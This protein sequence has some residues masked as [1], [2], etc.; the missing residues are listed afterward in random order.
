MTGQPVWHRCLSALVLVL[1]LVLV[2]TRRG[3][4]LW[5]WLGV[6]ASVAQ[7][8]TAPSE[9][10]AVLEL[11]RARGSLRC[12]GVP[13][14][15]LAQPLG[16]AQSAGAWQGLEPELCQAL[17]TATLGPAGRAQFLPL[18]TGVDVARVREGGADVVFASLAERQTLGL[19]GPWRATQPIY[20][21]GVSVMVPARSS[22]HRLEDLRGRGICFFI[23]STAEDALQDAM[24]ARA[25]L[26]VPH[27]FSELGEMQDAFAAHLCEALA[28][29]R[30][31][32]AAMR[33]M[34]AWQGL[35]ARL[36]EQDLGRFAIE[37]ATA[38]Q[39][40]AWAAWVGQALATL[41]A[42]RVGDDV[43]SSSRAALAQMIQRQGSYA[44]IYARTLGTDS[45]LALP[46]G[47]NRGR[48]QGGAL[49]DVWPAR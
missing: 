44:S 3:V 47:D 34:P 28:A 39:D 35:R 42:A 14:P 6:G 10:S 7:A 24:R 12:A 30:T 16:Q 17:A 33:A 40:P 29:E 41:V 5:L 26:W 20:V 15:G 27:A 13:R 8:Q 9:P 18:Q 36:F 25:W 21:Q 38:Q 31:D 4:W 43:P 37:A 1:V 19:A 32:L 45:A 48:R 2:L 46:E 11:V 22:L 49:A 23:G